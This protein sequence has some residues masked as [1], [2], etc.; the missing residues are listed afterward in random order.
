MRYVVAFFTLALIFMLSITGLAAN[1]TAK[2]TA[3]DMVLDIAPSPNGWTIHAVSVDAH[4]LLTTFA[5]KAHLQL[6]V[7][8]ALKRRITIHI[9]DKPALEVLKVVVDAYGF[10]WAEVDGMHIVSEGMPR[11]PSSYLLS[12]I[13]SVT[14]KYVTP[15]QAWALLPTFLQG[16]V[17]INTDQNAVILSGPRPVLEKFR[18]DVGRFDIPAE[19]IMLNVDVVEFTN[20]DTDTFAALLSYGN[21][22]FGITTDS[23]TGET[24]LTALAFLPTHFAARLQALVEQHKARVHANP[25]IATVSGRG[26][27]IF[28]G[29]QQYLTNPVNIPGRGNS[30]SIDAG[31]SLSIT[32][33]TGG[34]GE[35]ILDLSEEISTLSAPDAVTGLPTKTTRS[36]NSTIRVRDGQTVVIGGLRQAEDRSTRHAI[37]VLSK[38]PL[39]GSLFR[40]KRTETTMVD[41]A[42]FITA[43]TLSQTGHLPAAEEEQLKQM[44]GIEEKSAK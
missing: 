26:A 8:D 39:I 32:P 7:D 1:D 38:L 3:G 44:I 22:K 28:I 9:V 40:S 6:I 2:N 34:D 17:K 18:A 43:R 36:A 15:S 25:R 23:L 5:A 42:I 20:M 41:L 16:E 33:L 31:V 29:Q 10:A 37:P 35:I 12:D 13:A 30:Y 21:D 4:E 19:Q 24:T 14:T 11:S 27:S